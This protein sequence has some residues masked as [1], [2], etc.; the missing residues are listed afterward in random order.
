MPG[1][2]SPLLPG[3]CLGAVMPEVPLNPRV[4]GM[5]SEVTAPGI[6]VPSC[7]SISLHSF[8]GCFA[9]FPPFLSGWTLQVVV[10]LVGGCSEGGRPPWHTGPASSW[11]SL[12][13]VVGG[14]EGCL[15]S[16]LSVKNS[17]SLTRVTS[18]SVISCEGS[19][20]AS[21]L[22]CAGS[23]ALECHSQWKADCLMF[24]SVTAARCSV[25][26]LTLVSQTC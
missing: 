19:D 24:L 4:G 6:W 21:Y 16:Y 22:R 9:S 17:I 1:L 8:L 2:P 5:G 18:Q 10:P 13:L 11:R 3:L 23:G 14:W 12:S 20:A 15:H 26:K 7:G 25:K